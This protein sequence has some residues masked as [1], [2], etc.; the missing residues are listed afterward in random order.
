[1]CAR[2]ALPVGSRGCV[3]ATRPRMRELLAPRRGE[4]FALVSDVVT[5]DILLIDL[6][7]LYVVM[8]DSTYEEELNREIVERAR[9]DVLLLGFG[10]G[11]I[12]QPLMVNPAVASITIIEKYQEVLDLCASQLTLSDKVRVILADALEW[13]PDMMFD[14]IYDDCDYAPGTAIDNCRRL[15]PWLKPNGEAIRWTPPES[16]GYYV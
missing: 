8:S 5:G 7:Q 9:G 10:I 1:M 13:M 15:A 12:L 4:K 11:F 6:G 2:P 3:V 16:R 14:V